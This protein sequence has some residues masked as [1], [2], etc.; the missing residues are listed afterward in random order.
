MKKSIKMMILFIATILIIFM[1]T[2]VVNAEVE[3]PQISIE[4]KNYNSITGTIVD[5][6][7]LTIDYSNITDLTGLKIYYKVNDGEYKEISYKEDETNY[8]L[9]IQGN[10]F[11]EGKC[12]QKI[13]V[14]AENE[15]GKSEVLEKEFLIIYYTSKEFS[16]PNT[17]ISGTLMRYPINT[18]VEIEK[19]NDT[20]ILNQLSH[21]DIATIY[22]I[23]P[24][25]EGQDAGPLLKKYGCS[26]ATSYITVKLPIPE[27]VAQKSN[28][29][30]KIGYI[31]TSNLSEYKTVSYMNNPLINFVTTTGEYIYNDG[32]AYY[33][34]ATEKNEEQPEPPQEQPDNKPTEQP[35]SEDNK[36]PEKPKEESNSKNDNT[37]TTTV[38]PDTGITPIIILAISAVAIISLIAYIK[39]NNFKGI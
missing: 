30:D 6:Y 29:G 31:F 14:Y 9:T 38:I 3:A 18:T 28:Y 13:Y 32:Y 11:D 10:E 27:N 24:K 20:N 23:T 12:L 7:S 5:A 35:P 36:E 25:V 16:D 37:T 19:V 17:G 8:K 21:L 15:K 33:M 26:T 1:G 39:Y 22:K 34:I 2:T 4:G